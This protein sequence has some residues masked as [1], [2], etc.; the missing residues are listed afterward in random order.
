MSL[1]AV[2]GVLPVPPSRIAGRRTDRGTMICSHV[3]NCGAAENVEYSTIGNVEY[4][5]K[6]GF[7]TLPGSFC[8]M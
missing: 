1:E 7:E 5:S 2:Q 6:S 4:S 3:R 8:L